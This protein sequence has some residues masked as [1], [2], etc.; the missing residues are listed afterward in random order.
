MKQM[1]QR[2]LLPG[3]LR[4]T[5]GTFIAPAGLCSSAEESKE[6]SIARSKEDEDPERSLHYQM[7][8][9]RMSAISRATAKEKAIKFAP[10]SEQFQMS[11]SLLLDDDQ[12]FLIPAVKVKH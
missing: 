11:T 6:K 10:S 2:G 8:L 4:K 9:C 5:L 3:L 7:W 1:S 12:I